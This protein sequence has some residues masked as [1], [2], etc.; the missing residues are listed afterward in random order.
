MAAVVGVMPGA[1]LSSPLLYV[2]FGLV[3]LSILSGIM[4][5]RHVAWVTI[6]S[7]GNALGGHGYPAVLSFLSGMVVFVQYVLWN[8]PGPGSAQ[9]ARGAGAGDARPPAVCPGGYVCSHLF[10]ILALLCGAC[11]VGL[12]DQRKRPHGPGG[13]GVL[14]S[15]LNKSLS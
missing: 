4:W 10:S 13:G 9:T 2:A 15:L 12:R 8:S 3:L 14:G 7:E 11:A 6:S 5:I 1:S